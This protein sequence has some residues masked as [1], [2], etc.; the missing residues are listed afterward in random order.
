MI[1]PEHVKSELREPLGA[2]MDFQHF[3]SMYGKERIV[4]V[5]DAVVLALLRA[6]AEPFVSVYDFSTRR[7]PLP[8]S[9]KNELARKYQKPRVCEN[10]AGTIT[11]S[12]EESA[13][14]VLKTGGA[15]KVHGEEDL[16][17]LVFMRLCPNGLV[18]IYGQP[19]KG[20]VAIE[21]NE[22][23]RKK[24]EGFFERMRER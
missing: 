8:E 24:A 22:K 15:L 7:S 13:K 9:E 2:L 6:K 1:V 20:V 19:E 4:A 16:A 23:S 21:C 11:E 5:G 10:P 12:L 3:L 17:A 14:L 18:I